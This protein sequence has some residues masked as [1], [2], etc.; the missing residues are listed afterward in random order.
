MFGATTSEEPGAVG[1][2]PADVSAL[3]VELGRALKGWSF[4]PAG[5]PARQELLDRTARAFQGEL[6][7]NGGLALDIRRGAFWLAGGDAP[8]GAGRLDD[9]AR[10]LFVRSVRH[11][12]FDAALDATSL[13]A[14]LDVLAT[15]ADALAAAGGFESAFYTGMRHGCRVNEVDYRAL[16]ERRQAAAGI[17]AA[18][19]VGG[20]APSDEQTA[21]HLSL[22]SP[23]AIDDAP[24]EAD[25]REARA[26]ELLGLLRD[27]EEC[28]D[29]ARYRDLA[30]QAVTLSTAL[31]AD[32]VLDEGY[33]TL[34]VLSAHAG[35]DAKRSYAQR[36]SA[37][38]FLTHVAIGPALDDLVARA[39]ATTGEASLHATAVLLQLG[40]RAV[41]LL[42]DQL[43][44]E[45]D[46]DRR[47][48][49][50]GV[51]IAMGEEAVP[52]LAEAIVQGSRRRQRLALRLAG[53]TQNP[54][55]V[56]SLREAL[57][58]GRGEA[59]RDA[60]QSLVRVGDVSALEVLV[61]ALRSARSEV[62]ALAAYSLGTTGRVLSLGPLV[63]TLARTVARGDLALAREVV[64]GIGRLGRP[65]GVPALAELLASGGWLR[66]KKLRE[67]KLAAVSALAHL[68]G[69]EAE[70]AL[71]RAARARDARLREAAQAALERRER[72]AQ[73]A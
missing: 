33:R 68:P 55:L 6:R 40:S 22:P 7:R 64:R 44:V 16:L 26:L 45:S 52:A 30:R 8:I 48:R 36:E 66:R 21:P 10:Q 47:A 18:P 50:S 65:E 43:E 62:A 53:E 49:V 19:E 32:G 14:F 60:A 23:V 69:R 54:R 9:L 20:S 39:C 29:D 71:E 28:E 17:G 46:P 58:S 5:H 51:V 24:L 70:A 31:V 15:D 12:A 3:L 37:M 42:L 4:Y 67:V 73:P 61:E 1:R 35:D 41:P 34:L 38:Q 13:A 2:N 27:L 57:L 25:P 11:V 56:P 59:A 72:D 63:E